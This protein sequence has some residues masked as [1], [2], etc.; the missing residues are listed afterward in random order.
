LDEAG[1]DIIIASNTIPPIEERAYRS[2]RKKKGTKQAPSIFETV[3]SMREVSES[4]VALLKTKP[5][6][7]LISPKVGMYNSFEVDKY[8]EF[9][10]AGEE[11]T[12]AEIS[13]IKA[14]VGM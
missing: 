2:V 14:L 1:A 11:A 8:R 3:F 4:L 13:R 10:K 7:V 9:I 6:S 12:E 5:Y